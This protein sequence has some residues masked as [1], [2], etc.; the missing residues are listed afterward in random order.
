MQ[1]YELDVGALPPPAKLTAPPNAEPEE[2]DDIVGDAADNST[3]HDIYETYRPAKLKE[4]LPHPDPIVETASLAS[5]EPPEVKYRH[6]LQDCVAAG[7]ISDAQ[8][9]TIVYA[10]QRFNN[11]LPVG[12]GQTAPR[13]GFFLGDGAGVGKGRQ[14]AALIKEHWRTGGRRA[15]WVSVSN[16][17]KYDSIRDL[18]DVGADAIKVFPQR[19]TLPSASVRLD[20]EWPEGVLFVTYSL[21]ISGSRSGGK[22]DKDM[23]LGDS[24]QKTWKIPK[25]SRLK[26]I[27]E[28]LSG[29]GGEPLIIFDEC[30]K[31]KN[32]IGAK[33]KASTQTGK[34]VLNLQNHLPNAKIL[35]SSATGASE[36]KNLA[37]M[38]RLG[39]AGFEDMSKMIQTLDSSGLGALELFS[40]GLKATGTYLSR[41]LSYAGAEFSIAK[42]PMEAVFNIMYNRSTELWHMLLRILRELRL[43]RKKWGLFFSAQ[44]RFYRQMLMAA[45]VPE[46]AKLALDAVEKQ[47]M[48]VVIGLQSTGE[49]NTEAKRRETGDEMEDFV[50]APQLILQQFLENHFPVCSKEL[51]SD[52]LLLMQHQIYTSIQAWKGMRPALKEAEA[53]LRQGAGGPGTSAAAAAAVDEEPEFVEQKTLDE[54][55][56]D[57]K[58]AAMREGRFIDLSRAE[59]GTGPSAAQLAATAKALEQEERDREAEARRKDQEMREAERRARLAEAEAEVEAAQAAINA[60]QADEE[61]SDSDDD[62]VKPCAA[63][64]AKAATGRK[65][66]VRKAA[67]PPA[68]SDVCDAD[69]PLDS[70]STGEGK[71]KAPKRARM[72]CDDDEDEDNNSAS[73]APA[74]KPG[75]SAR[76]A[77]GSAQKARRNIVSDDEDEAEEDKSGSALQPASRTTRGKTPAKSAAGKATKPRAKQAGPGVKKAAAASS[78]QKQPERSSRAEDSV[79]VVEDSASKGG[80]VVKREAGSAQKRAGRSTRASS[81]VIIVED[82]EEEGEEMCSP[83]P[84][85]RTSKAAVADDDEE[86]AEEEEEPVMEVHDDTACQVCGR[87]DDEEHLVLCDGCDVGC[88]IY[89]SEPK[90]ET[91]PEG[92]WFCSAE[93]RAKGKP[94]EASEPA[95]SER[96]AS[97]TSGRE[98]PTHLDPDSP[99]PA[100]RKRL[101]TVMD[102]SDDDDFQQPSKAV[103]RSAPS[104]SAASGSDSAGGSARAAACRAQRGKAASTTAVAKAGPSRLSKTRGAEAVA[105][106]ATKPPARRKTMRELAAERRLKMAQEALANLVKSSNTS[107][108]AATA[109]TTTTTRGA[110][111]QRLA[112]MYREA[113]E[114]EEE[115]QDDE[116]YIDLVSEDSPRDPRQRTRDMK[117]NVGARAGRRGQ[118]PT[119]PERTTRAEGQLFH[120]EY[121]AAVKNKALADDWEDELEDELEDLADE[122]P[123]DDEG[124]PS[125]ILLRIRGMLLRQVQAMELP[126]NPL[127]QLTDLLGG[128]GKVAEMTGRKSMLVKKEDGKVVTQMRNTEEAQKMVNM[129]EKK[130][131]MDGDKLIAIISEAASTGISLQADKRVPNQLRRCH[132]TLELPWSADK[133]IQQFG[134]SHR[135]NQASAPVYRIIVTDCAGEFRMASAAAKR[136]MSLGALLKGD[137]RAMG[138]GADL[139]EFDVDNHWGRQTL[140]RVYNDLLGSTEPM[141]NVKVL[142]V[143]EGHR[144]PNSLNSAMDDF[145]EWACAAMTKV[146]LLEYNPRMGCLHPY[147]VEN[148]D[149]GSVK[150]FLNRLLAMRLEEQKTIFQYFS[151]TLDVI[152]ATAK[153]Q[154][155]YETGITT[156]Q[157]VNGAEVK[158]KILIH[159]DTDSG[160]QTFN[161]EVAIDR[162]VSWE[163]ALKFRD[164]WAADWAASGNA[165][166]PFVGFHLDNHIKNVGG[167]GHPRVIMVT[168]TKAMEEGQIKRYRV[169]RPNNCLSG[170]QWSEGELREKNYIKISDAT[171]K[172]HWEFWYNFLEDHCEHGSNCSRRSRG[173]ECFHGQRVTNIHLVTGAVLPIWKGL[174]DTVKFSSVGRS[175]EGKKDMPRVVRIPLTNGERI[176]GL[177]LLKEDAQAVERN[178]Y[179]QFGPP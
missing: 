178:V 110:R 32:L 125:P 73:V 142:E 10:N 168:Q 42:V 41:T 130:H 81:S 115:D 177:R 70:R 58:Q 160:A 156:I 15:L 131:F 136:L 123:D 161:A 68:A 22:D 30:H 5:M 90:M 164:D 62:L 43:P 2:R 44:Q 98:S 173:M 151:E 159:T 171:A 71:G 153:S 45:K 1:Q 169:Q 63:A 53:L 83:P 54:V 16:D 3:E 134:R 107:T 167:T 57:Q 37:Y 94:A 176:V 29:K 99:S 56:E 137:R 89:C 39:M 143:P 47:G 17:L 77:R 84:N 127:D 112:G 8:L 95:A 55:L 86:E 133:A 38:N 31:A 11:R 149:K 6:H 109:G 66:L 157:G 129:R 61:E 155:K 163:Q 113:S 87:T 106:A 40:M 103:K 79:E 25:G 72:L 35:Y 23:E 9:E 138:A 65:R 88:H 104:G 172:R 93:C 150:R 18:E 50:S 165:D 33:G 108:P 85:K 52:E 34:A 102:S 118:A 111:A 145:R 60:A 36:P 78:A 144:T 64:P 46:T 28:W 51:S 105:K 101:K 20:R 97:D 26:Q 91:V 175:S 24:T 120:A 59:A 139:K 162:G 19:S 128:S 170:W 7:H 82:S 27:V 92:D 148:K 174:T 14:I 49:A 154:G 152:I 135:S 141:A 48:C 21:L 121:H 119:P 96:A 179:A 122:V 76:K 69:P 117:P 80:R 140:E 13:A 67:S 126:A 4:G 166:N 124:V 132:L 75:G 147:T 74:N 114:D 158:Q 116:D 100:K 146:G 12:A